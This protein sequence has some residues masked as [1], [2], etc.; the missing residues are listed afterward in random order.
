MPKN[1]WYFYSDTKKSSGVSFFPKKAQGQ[2]IAQVNKA[3]CKWGPKKKKILKNALFFIDLLK[4]KTE[5]DYLENSI[6]TA[7]RQKCFLI[8]EIVY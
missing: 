8:Y 2:F 7:E 6:D 4:T 5:F 3:L 1:V